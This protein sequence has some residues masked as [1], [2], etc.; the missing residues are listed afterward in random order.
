[1]INAI[2]A[3]AWIC[4]WTDADQAMFDR[5]KKKFGRSSKKCIH[6]NEWIVLMKLFYDYRTEFIVLLFISIVFHPSTP[7]ISPSVIEWWKTKTS[8]N[9]DFFPPHAYCF[10]YVKVHRNL[11]FLPHSTIP[12]QTW[13]HF[14]R[15]LFTL[16]TISMTWLQCGIR[17]NRPNSIISNG[18]LMLTDKKTE[19]TN[20]PTSSLNKLSISLFAIFFF[21]RKV[22]RKLANWEI[23]FDLF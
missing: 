23:E 18:R 13:S 20:P 17:N 3:Y 22:T 6:Q 7:S 16:I 5:E 9:V 10:M 19:R 11:A 4:Y 21:I 14:G 8:G 2:Y 12:F 1:M 15:V